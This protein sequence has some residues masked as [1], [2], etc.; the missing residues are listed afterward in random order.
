[1]H[2]SRVAWLLAATAVL[3]PA[4]E[5]RRIIST[6]PSITEILYA[7]GLGDRVAGVTQYCRYPVEAQQ[8]PKIG[9]FLEPDFERI[10]SLKPDL[11]LVIKNPIQVAEKLRKLGVRAEEINQ[12]SV[13]DVFRSIE[14]IGQWTGSTAAARKMT[15]GMRSQLDEIRAKTKGQLRKKTLFLVGRSP[16][17]LQGM[18]AA[19]PRTFIDELVGIAGGTNL[20]Q[21]SPIQYPKVSVEQVL[22]GDPDVILDMGDFAHLEGKPLEARNDFLTL[23]SRYPQLRAVR[24]KQVIQIDSDV[25]IHPGPRIGIAVRALYQNLHGAKAR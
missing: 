20:L 3:C 21:N 10:L 2:A 17:T 4:A 24:S 12:D 1:M 18:V 15:A 5:P 6:A 22:A 11:V 7:L 23:W 9:S 19:G 13:E 14:L 16:G 25:F 8:K